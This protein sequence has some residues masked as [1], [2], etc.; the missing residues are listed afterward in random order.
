ML[1]WKTTDAANWNIDGIVHGFPGSPSLLDSQARK[2]FETTSR[3]G[4]FA[5]FEWYEKVDLNSKPMTELYK[6]LRE[7]NV[8]IDPTLIAFRNGFYGDKKS[9]I[10][11]PELRHVNPE[12]LNNWRT[13]FTFNLGWNEQDYKRARKVW[14]KVL[15]F[16]KRLYDEGISLTIGTDLGNPWVIPGLSVHQEMQIFV[17]AGIPNRDILKMAT[18]DAASRLGIAKTH[19]SIERGK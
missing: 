2:E 11:H 10:E 9:V 17:N 13:F 4:T 16:V 15:G 19:G 18:I 1:I 7:N 5:F 3:P 14:P 12:L 8:H 6:A